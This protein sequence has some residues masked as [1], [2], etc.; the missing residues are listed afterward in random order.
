MDK[1]QEKM[2]KLSSKVINVI[3]ELDYISRKYTNLD[4]WEKTEI[5]T[6]ASNILKK[7][8]ENEIAEMLLFLKNNNM[9]YNCKNVLPSDIKKI[10]YCVR[11][12]YA[13]EVE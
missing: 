1:H 10:K 12:G 8:Y 11:C 9:C 3:S 4:E 7:E 13:L 2:E 6:S 5:V